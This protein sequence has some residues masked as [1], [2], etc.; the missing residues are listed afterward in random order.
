MTLA[1]VSGARLEA[2]TTRP[3]TCPLAGVSDSLGGDAAEASEAAV[4]DNTNASA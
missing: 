3:P 4:H 1:S 2:T